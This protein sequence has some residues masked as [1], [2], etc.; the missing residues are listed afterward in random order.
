MIRES[1]EVTPP[2]VSQSNIAD[3]SVGNAVQSPTMTGGWG[4]T[5][6]TTDQ[7]SVQESFP[8]F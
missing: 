3:V 4:R 8:S 7:V 2:Q 6:K 5:D 1:V